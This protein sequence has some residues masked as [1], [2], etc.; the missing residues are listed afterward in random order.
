MKRENGV[1]TTVVS[2]SGI[3]K[4]HIE[5]LGIPQNVWPENWLSQATQPE[6]QPQPT[7]TLS[8]TGCP[9]ATVEEQTQSLIDEARGFCLLYPASH[10]AEQLDSGNTEIVLGSVMNHTN[11]RASIVVENLA[12]RSLEQAVEEFL[13]GY[14]GFDIER[15]P[16]IVGGEAAIQLDHIPGQD[17]YRKV[18]LARDGSLYQL[19]FSPYDPVLVDSFAQAEHIYRIVIDSFHF[20]D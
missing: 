15:T 17:Y 12:G 18:I 14:E 13:A 1:W 6:I 4:E 11:L 16:L 10:T 5:A 8:A 7:S 9:T 19:S 2:G 3:E 20:V